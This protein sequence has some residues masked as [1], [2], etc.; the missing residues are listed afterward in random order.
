MFSGEYDHSI[1]S[2]GRIII[3][4]RFREELGQD[5]MLTKGLDNC[6]YLFPA[7]AWLRFR[8]KLSTMPISSGKA[9]AFNR[10]F[11][12]SMIVT[13]ELDKQGRLNISAKHREHAQIVKDVVTIGMDDHIEIWSRER[14][15]A[16]LQSPEMDSRNIAEGL[17][18]LGI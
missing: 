5:F 6:L 11:Y 13:K 17:E 8:E 12:S 16:Y 18:E 3:P 7:Q 15:E 9:R 10:F 4:A 14:W 1:D 2:K